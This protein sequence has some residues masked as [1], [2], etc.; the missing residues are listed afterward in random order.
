MKKRLKK[1]VMKQ[2]AVKTE[3]MQETNVKEKP[4]KLELRLSESIFVRELDSFNNQEFEAGTI[5]GGGY[6]DRLTAKIKEIDKMF[7]PEGLRE[8]AKRL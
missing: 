8:Q 3:R 1:K 6:L 2:L 5:Y 7:S 4:T